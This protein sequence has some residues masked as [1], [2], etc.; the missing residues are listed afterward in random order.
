GHDLAPLVSLLPPDGPTRL[1]DLT[2]V[3]WAVRADERH[4][5]LFVNN[6]QRF[7]ALGEKPDVQFKIEL[8]DGPLL[9]PETGTITIPS[10]A[11]FLWPFN[12]DLGGVLL[13]YATAE[14]LCHLKDQDGRPVYVFFAAHGIELGRASCRDGEEAAMARACGD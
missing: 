14:P 7:A 13:R 4:G 11:Y 2:S 8:A 10:G 1:S 5:Y 3:R 6:Y 12:M 9:I